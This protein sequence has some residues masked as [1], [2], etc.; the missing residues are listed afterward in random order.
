[1][2]QLKK[3]LHEKIIKG[4][5]DLPRDTEIATG[6]DPKHEGVWV[7]WYLPLVTV[8][9]WD[10]KLK[11]CSVKRLAEAPQL[12]QSSLVQRFS[13]E[14][15]AL[16]VIC[17]MQTRQKGAKYYALAYPDPTTGICKAFHLGR[18][19]SVFFHREFRK[20]ELASSES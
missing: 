19:T 13:P 14:Q 6:S 3:D 16:K 8:P 9:G 20:D 4:T 1:M 12:P 15:T 18:G 5:V 2:E 11:G 17:R 7:G 10:M